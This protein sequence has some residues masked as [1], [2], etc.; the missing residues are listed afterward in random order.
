MEDHEEKKARGLYTKRHYLENNYREAQGKTFKYNCINKNTFFQGQAHKSNQNITRV[1][2]NRNCVSLSQYQSPHWPVQ[3]T[4]IHFFN[5]R[6]TLWPSIYGWTLIFG[7]QITSQNL[8]VKLGYD[9]RQMSFDCKL[10]DCNFFW[11]L[12]NFNGL[13]QKS[14]LR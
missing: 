13:D 11:S 1:H 8:N 14:Y 10:H 7:S 12:K 2:R 5:G 3:S 6:H 4:L 9:L